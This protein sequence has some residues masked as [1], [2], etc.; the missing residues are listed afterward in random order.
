MALDLSTLTAA[1]QVAAIYIGYYDRAGEPDGS[2]FWEGAVANPNFSLEAI[3][4]DFSTQQETLDVHPFFSSPSAETANAFITSV[5]LSLFNREPDADGLTFWSGV[6]QAAIDGAGAMSVGAIILEIIEGAQD[7]AAG[8]DRATILNKIEVATAWTD[9]AEAAGLTGVAFADLSSAQQ[10]SAKSIIEPVTDSSA[11]VVSAKA[12]IADVFTPQGTPGNDLFLTSATDVIDEVGMPNQVTGQVQQATD[13]D[14][15]FWGYIAQ[16]PFAGGVSNSLSSADRLDGEGGNDRLYAELSL[17]F[18]GATADDGSSTRTDIQPRLTSIEEIDIEARDDTEAGAN[19]NDTIIVDAKHIIDHQEIGS[20]YSDGDLVIENLTTL[21]ESGAARNTA[22]ITV[23]MD[24]TDNFNS[25]DD[26]SDLTVYFDNDYLLAGET[27][28]G[29]ADFFLL[30]QDAELRLLRGQ[31]AEGRLDEIGNNGIRFSING[32]EVEVTFDGALLDEDAPDEINDHDAFIAALQADLQAEIAAGNLPEGTQIVRFDYPNVIF[33]DDG[34]ALNRAALQDGSFSDLIPAVR[35][36]SGDGSPVTPLGFTVPDENTDPFN[37]FGRVTADFEEQDQPITVDIELEKAGRGG[38][39]GDLI[40][41]G[42]A[43]NT[44]EGIAGGIEVFNIS[45]K[46]IGGDGAL[47]KPSNVG[48]ITSTLGALSTVNIVTDPAYADGDSFASLV[49]RNGF[50]QDPNANVESGDLKLVDAN[51]FKGNLTLGDIDANMN[52][53]RITNLDTLTALG[54]G[55]VEFNALLDGNE[56]DQDYTY[57]T[58]A[59]SDIVSV[60]ATGDALDYA[61]AGLRISTGEGAD[62]VSVQFQ[63]DAE[64]NNNNQLNQAIIDDVV[65]NTGGGNDSVTVDGVGVANILAGSGDDFVN[66]S[67]AGA[68]SIWAFNFD[69]I[70]ADAQ[71][72]GNITADDL[73]GVQPSLAYVGGATITVTLSGAGL[74]GNLAA[75]GGVMAL[76]T[77]DATGA[78][79]YADGYEATATVLVGGSNEH[80]GTQVDVN[81]AIKKAI[82]DDP[83][84]SK[85]LTVADGAN[86][87]LVISSTTSGAFAPEDLRIEIDQLDATSAAYANAVLTEAQNV[88]QNSDLTLTQLWGTTSFASA[89]QYQPGAPAGEAGDLTNGAGTNAWFDG[90]S[91]DGETA[92]QANDNLHTAGSADITENDNVIDGGAGNDLIV[93][94]TDA[95]ADGVTAF[96]T[97][98]QNALIDGAS[99]E[100]VVMTTSNFGNDTVMNFTTAGTGSTVNAGVDFLDFTAYLTSMQNLTAASGSQSDTLIPVTL[101]TNLADVQANEVSIVRFDNTDDAAETFANLSASDVEQLFNNGASYTGFNGD[102][103]YGNLAASAA[104]ADDEY[105]E[106]LPATDQLINGAGKAVI[107]IENNDNRGEY[108]VFELT[109]NGD[110]SNDADSTNNGVVS[111]TQLGSL[112]FG[113]SLDGIT[114]ANLVGTP[115]YQALLAAGLNGGAT[116][117]GGTGGGGTGGGGTGGGTPVDLT[118]QTAVAAVAGTAETFVLTFDSSSGNALSS[119]A[120]VS[121]TGFDPAEDILRFDDANATPQAASTFLNGAGGAVVASNGFAGETTISFQDDNA[122][123]TVPPAQVTLVG[124]T[125]ATLGG[126]TPFFEV[127]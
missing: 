27:S 68:T 96:T 16:N 71:G 40:V 87:T 25:D 19:P 20:Y 51:G 114:A 106:N 11:T 37:V 100:T 79:A 67:G 119:D 30:D 15:T 56:R 120:V 8:N 108:K 49:V 31:D 50:D 118:G 94:S 82:A 66:T 26:A 84:L 10:A 54:G 86:N 2:D 43:Q 53:G 62:S 32:Q 12:T 23:T 9:A 126:A 101:D 115:E 45:V 17:E 52:A 122:A 107:L 75:G 4:Q 36:I 72:L 91:A 59:G 7:T 98:S 38:E 99:N 76:D 110:A 58:G 121:I 112:D 127:V 39:G 88:F 5:Y 6:L 42:K 55:N 1:Q 125:D 13:D 105:T 28:V 77:D 69:D 80:Y 18:L 35:V 85:L 60:I 21:L 64:D 97:S 74:N 111:A 116:G 83:I 22:E 61:D 90:L 123:D 109:W 48:T 47:A 95:V 57:T 44:S 93:L 73:P 124:I 70:R 41:G 34:L 102:Q 65:I 78:I 81:N 46:G 113:D 29:Q 89:A 103:N 63:F 24:H 14:D 117:G 104:N 3:A 33:D 92:N